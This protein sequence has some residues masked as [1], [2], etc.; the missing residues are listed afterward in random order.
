MHLRDRFQT[1]SLTAR[2]IP[3]LRPFSSRTVRNRLR[4]RQARPRR[5]AIRPIVLPMHHVSRL[6]WCRRHL[7]FKRQDWTNIQFTDE[8]R[9]HLDSSDD[10]CLLDRR[11]GER[12][13]DT[14]VIK[15]QL[16][17][18]GSVMVWGGITE[19][20]RTPLVVFTGNLTRICY[21][22]EIVQRYV[23]PFTQ[24]QA[25]NVTFKEDNARPHVVRDYLTQHNVDV[26]SWPAVLPDLSP[27][28][29][30]WD[31]MEL[32]LRQLQNQLVK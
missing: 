21:R 7:R 6:T 3:G 22:H 18:G 13:V 20:G 11:L 30:V 23:F 4:D 32:R 2:S 25:N 19:R 12:Y 8:S 28:V 26:L 27:I 16:F 5:T 14:C 29:H 17:V 24:A 1:S 15:R 9:F 31:E 10:Q